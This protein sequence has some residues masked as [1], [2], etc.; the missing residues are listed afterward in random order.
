MLTT[1][2]DLTG[3]TGPDLLPA[4]LESATLLVTN[5]SGPM[6]IVAAHGYTGDRAVRS[7]QCCCSRAPMEPN[8]GVRPATVRVVRVLAE[9]AEI[10][11]NLNV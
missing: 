2:I 11:L 8:I 6:H 5:D 9:S 3:K 7:N 10:L 4:L 1:P